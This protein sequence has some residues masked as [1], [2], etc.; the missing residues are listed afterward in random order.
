MDQALANMKVVDLTHHIAGPYATKLLA[1]FG[2]DVIKIERPKEGDTCRRLGPFPG[3][4]PHPEKSGLFLHLNTNKRSITLNLKTGTGQLI[5]KELVK[6][7]DVVVESFRPGVMASFGLDYPVLERINPNL[8]MASISNFGQT[9]PYRDFKA[10][11]LVLAGMGGDQSRGGVAEKEPL[12]IA[13]RVTQYMAGLYAVSGILGAFFASR[14]QGEGGQY[15]DLSLMELLANYSDGR[16]VSLVRYQFTKLEETRPPHEVRVVAYPPS[17]A[18]PCQDGYVEWFGTARWAQ[19]ARML[20]RPDFLTDPRYAT[21][22]ARIR[23]HE[24]INEILLTWMMGRTK[25]QCWEEAMA[26]DVIC[27]PCNTLE[28]LIQ[29][30]HIGSRGFWTEVAHPALGKTTVPGRPLVL[31]ESPWRLRRPAPLLG[32]H[33]AEVLGELGYLEGDLLKMSEAGVI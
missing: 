15:L 7:A 18:Y 6:G 22:E 20:G 19:T 31:G 23:N 10:S 2:A 30:P 33:N 4:M 25:K 26:A 1:D 5:F 16:G 11:D 13:R 21:P 3:D 14:W 12:K 27:A 9:G 8:V 17:G 24:E 32:E 29:D 28:E